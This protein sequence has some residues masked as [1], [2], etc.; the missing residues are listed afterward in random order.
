MI[1]L[2]IQDC[3]LPVYAYDFRQRALLTF[4]GVEVTGLSKPIR[5]VWAIQ[6]V[7]SFLASIKPLIFWS[8]TPFDAISPYVFTRVGTWIYRFSR[9]DYFLARKNGLKGDFGHSEFTDP[10]SLAQLSTCWHTTVISA[11]LTTNA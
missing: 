2:N 6:T 1:D 10:D 7:S 3:D 5:K 4:D 9:V 11:W 8:T